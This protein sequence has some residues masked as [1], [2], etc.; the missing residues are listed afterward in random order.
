MGEAVTLPA[1][2]FP[3]NDSFLFVR[4]ITGDEIRSTKRRGDEGAAM[5]I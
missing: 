1:T 3:H 2:V 5:P 4:K